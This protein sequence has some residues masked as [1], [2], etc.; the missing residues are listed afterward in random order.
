MRLIG[1]GANGGPGD[2]RPAGRPEAAGYDALLE[3]ALALQ[4]ALRGGL[5]R[6]GRLLAALKHLRRQNRLVESTLA[7]LRQLQPPGR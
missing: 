2:G 3:E 1:G 4:D 5:A 7:S 6:A